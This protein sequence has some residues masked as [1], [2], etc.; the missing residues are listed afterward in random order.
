MLNFI[1]NI[2]INN[3]KSIQNL[4]IEDFNRINLFIGR[5]NT[6]KSNLLEALSLFSLPYYKYNQNKKITNF[7]RLENKA[8][9]FFDGNVDAPIRIETNIA[10]CEINY[11]NTAKTTGTSPPLLRQLI[12]NLH[13]KQDNKALIFTLDE[14]LNIKTQSKI[15]LEYPLKKYTFTS[16]NQSKSDGFSFLL[17]PYGDNL[18]Q[19]ITLHKELKNELIDLFS[20]YGLKLAFDKASRTIKVVKQNKEDDLFLI[21]Y[22]S[23]ADTLQR[24]IFFKSAIASNK[25]SVLLFEEPEAHSFPP[26]MAHITQKIIHA[27]NNQ[28]FISTH[29]PYIINDF[30]ENSRNDLAI[31]STD[32]KNGETVVRKLTKNEIDDIFQ[33]GIDVFANNEIFL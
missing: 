23:I 4:V 11:I 28:F 7:I 3:F 27:A 24:L 12:I 19:V 1:E 6:G 29:S 14:K 18:L 10:D 21:P 32:Y 5:P 22:N 25:N 17:P 16:D 31:F 15:E 13:F 20:E 8:E 26:Y 2:T 9:L 33:Y 30:L